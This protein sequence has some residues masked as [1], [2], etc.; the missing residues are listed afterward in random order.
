MEAEA[1]MGKLSGLEILSLLHDLQKNSLNTSFIRITV[2]Q[3]DYD[4]K[5]QLDF[6][7]EMVVF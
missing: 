3:I 7:P 4:R 5:V 6:T 2:A 1:T